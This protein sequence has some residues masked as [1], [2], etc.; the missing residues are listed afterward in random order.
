MKLAALLL[1]VG[2]AAPKPVAPEY[3]NE[4]ALREKEVP[5]F[6]AHLL[7]DAC[8]DEATDDAMVAHAQLLMDGCHNSVSVCAR[9]VCVR[10]KD[11]DDNHHLR[12]LTL[13]DPR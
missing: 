11:W 5:Q 10:I 12:S 4:F 1:L 9:Y 6:V 3:C 2:C 8:T 7:V 13:T